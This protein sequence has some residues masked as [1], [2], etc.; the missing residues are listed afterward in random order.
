MKKI[1]LWVCVL[2]CAFSSE[3]AYAQDKINT[4]PAPS[5][6]TQDNEQEENSAMNKLER[7][8]INVATCWME[9]PD[10]V[11]KG[12]KEEEPVKGTILGIIGG[13]CATAL[14]AVTGVLDVVTFWLPPYNKP[15]MQPEYA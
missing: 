2:A 9:V 11:A 13:A 8:A 15:L 6:I 1:C 5:S 4:A 3:I 14:R 10:G 12:N 7:G